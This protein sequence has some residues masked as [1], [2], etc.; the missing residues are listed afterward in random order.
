MTYFKS[1]AIIQQYGLWQ[2]DYPIFVYNDNIQFM[3]VI[4]GLLLV[5]STEDLSVGNLD[6]F[7]ERAISLVHETIRLLSME[8]SRED[9][10]EYRISTS[11]WTQA[12][13]RVES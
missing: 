3:Y 10:L 11:L 5:S 8:E 7:F 13:F 6:R 4:L 12:Y 1:Y 9:V 2:I